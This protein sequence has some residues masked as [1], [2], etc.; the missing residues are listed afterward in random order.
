M[1]RV[2]LVILCLL[3]FILGACVKQNTVVEKFTPVSAFSGRILVMSQSH[4]FQLAVDWKSRGEQ[5]E[6]RLTHGS[7]GRIVDIVWRN[8]KMRWRDNAQ[9]VLWADL[10]EQALIEMGVILP[11]WLLANIFLGEMPDTMVTEDNRAWKGTWAENR[12]SVRWA[13]KQQKVDLLDIKH[14]RRVV[15]VFDE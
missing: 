9:S 5:G 14:G 11:P 4:R 13:S 1:K 12:L 6:M 2:R 10:S 3:P 7:S 15:V 8:K